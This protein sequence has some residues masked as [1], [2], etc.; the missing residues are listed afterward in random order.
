MLHTLS[1]NEDCSLPSQCGHRCPINQQ[2]SGGERRHLQPRRAAALGAGRRASGTGDQRA[3]KQGSQ[4]ERA[5]GLIIRA[6]E[7]ARRALSNV[8]SP[9]YADIPLSDVPRPAS[10]ARKWCTA[11]RRLLQSACG[12]KQNVCFLAMGGNGR[13][14]V[15][16][17]LRG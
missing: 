5:R 13:P 7:A 11:D 9:P 6:R 17:R 2:P 10:N 15:P 8:P 3:R 12:R 1:R 16:S 14:E 4:S